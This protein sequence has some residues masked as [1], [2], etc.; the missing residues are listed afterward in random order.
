MVYV[1]LH[2]GRCF[3]LTPSLLVD[4]LNCYWRSDCVVNWPNEVIVYT[5]DKIDKTCIGRLPTFMSI[6][7]KCFKPSD[8]KED[9]GLVSIS[10]D[11]TSILIIKQTP[12]TLFLTTEGN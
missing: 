12:V 6:R 8:H 11:G 1:F 7:Y 5:A 2:P 4:Q 9:G 3:G 10:K